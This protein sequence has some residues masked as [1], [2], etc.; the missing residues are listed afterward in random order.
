MKSALSALLLLAF[1]AF[2]QTRG[3]LADYALVLEDPPVAQAVAQ[4]TQPRLALSSADAQA[5]LRRI[6][7]VQKRMLAELVRRKVRVVSTS[8]ILVNAIFVSTTRETALQL[9]TI[10]G[11]HY[12]QF[13]PPVARDLNAAA[14]LVNVGTAYSAVGGASNAGAGIKI[15]IID[16]GIDQNHPGFQDS[17]L[18]VPAGFPK[19][20]S[21]FTN[22]KVIVARSYVSL[23]GAGFTTN[24]VETSR[25]DDNSPRDRVGHGTGI[26][27]IAA[28]VQNTGPAGTIQGIAPKAFLGNYKIFGSPGVNDFTNAAAITQALTDAIADGMDIVT[29]SIN[30]GDPAFNGPFDVDQDPNFCGGPCDVRAQAVKSAVAQ[31]MVVVTSAGNT[32]GPNGLLPSTL[33]TVHTPGTEPAAITVGASTNSHLVYQAVHVSGSGVPTNLQNV[34]ALFSDG[35]RIAAPLTA[36]IRDVAQLQNDGLACSALPAGSLNG[37]IALIQRGGTCFFSDK[38]NFAQGAGAVGVI[39]YQLN[40]RDDILN[41]LVGAQTTG[42]PA[43]AIGNSDGRALKS[44]LAS[45]SAVT[46]SLDPAFATAGATSNTAASFSS[47]GPAIGLFANAADVARAIKPEL[48]AP[49]DS[50]YTATQ[51]FDPNGDVYNATGYAAVSGTSYAVPIVAGAV[52]LVKQKN[53]NIKTPA[54]LKSAV[55]NTATQDVTDGGA[56][57]RVNAVGAGKLSVVDAVNVAATLEPATLAFGQIT[58][59]TVSLSLTLQVTNVSSASATFSFAVPPQRD[60]DSNATVRVS[61]PSLTLQ[62]NTSNQVS[63]TLTGTLPKPGNYE[64]FIVV[65]GA[66]PTLRVPYQY[67]VSDNVPANVFSINNNTFGFPNSQ[68]WGI[69]LR[70]VDQYGIPLV[71]KP[72]NFGVKQGKATIAGGDQQT[73]LYGIAGADINLGS[74]T[75]NQIFTGT[76]GGL[77]V[78]FDGF[79]RQLPTLPAGSVV[80]AA[81]N[82]QAG[83]GMAPGSYISIFGSALSDATAFVSTPSLPVSLAGVSI[84]FDG[85]GLSLPGHIH[86]VSPGQINVQIPWEFQGQSSVQ[87]KVTLEDFLWS[88][89]YTVPLA[90]YAPGVFAIT[91]ANG[92]VISQA[93]PAKGGQTIIVYANGLG[94]V[95][96]PIVSG[97]PTPSTQPLANTRVTPSVNIGGSTAQVNFS[98]LTPGSVGLYQ[99]NV[100]VPAGAPNGTQQMRISIGGVDSLVN[101]QVQ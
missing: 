85:G 21:G 84:S 3:R 34:Q 71:G 37:A 35:P 73:F 95:D 36:P 59:T 81:P 7:A 19:G 96:Q 42:I 78:E 18:T 88:D 100:V 26:A 20:D 39:I 83:Q 56:V 23:V 5:Q 72:A 25:P 1:A 63:V 98:G 92:A 76:A 8:Q 52:A 32:G 13:L 101:L 14:S 49:G 48:V 53:G 47:R 75:G 22:R 50:L 70:L 10:P 93:N 44:L 31:G 67:L 91:D 58:S 41:V 62:P 97:D 4:K 80:S 33:G 16:T 82:S 65:S 43:V 86:F 89:I 94:P 40:G 90:T 54:Q 9:K 24:P 60:T 28:G 87:M 74:D 12:V 55:V 29:L 99:M 79:S 6:G 15:G 66:G 38:I 69:A 64:G 27:M 46:A 57:A 17:S 61:L 68:G 45:N 11:V 77:S 51:K 30:E 2:G